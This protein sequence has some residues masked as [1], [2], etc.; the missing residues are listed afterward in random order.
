[1][2][3][4]VTKYV[5]INLSKLSHYV[6]LIHISISTLSD[7]TFMLKTLVFI[8]MSVKNLSVTIMSDK[9]EVAPAYAI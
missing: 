2:G 3:I 9:V 1:M 5:H 6:N 7:I 8:S 4:R